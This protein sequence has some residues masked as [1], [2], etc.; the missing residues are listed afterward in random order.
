MSS[1]DGAHK[2]QILQLRTATKDDIEWLYDTFKSTMRDYIEQTWGWDEV[3]QRH[4]FEQNLP[5][6]SF[7][8]ASIGNEDIGAYSVFEKRDHLWLEIALIVA[9]KQRA[10]FGRLLL[11][12]IQQRASAIQKPI[13]LNVLKINPALQF[14]ER[15]GFVIEGQDQWSFKMFWHPNTE[16]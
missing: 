10:G 15:I 4:S 1:K 16:A 8:I 3:M 13:R 9:D 11:L 6:A 2:R 12:E 7:L 5:P 14:Y